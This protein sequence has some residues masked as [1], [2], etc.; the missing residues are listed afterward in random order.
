M[1]ICTKCHTPRRDDEFGASLLGR[2]G[3]STWCL[4]CFREYNRQY[5]KQRRQDPTHREQQRRYAETRDPDHVRTIRQAS[6]H[7]KYV[8]FNAL[9][10]E[11]CLD[12]CRSFD[13]CCMD[14][15]HVHGNKVKDLAKMVVSN[16]RERVLAEIAKCE[17]VCACCHRVRTSIQR[18]N[19]RH[20]ASTINIRTFYEKIDVLKSSP[21]TDC[22][23]VFPAA[24][25]FDHIL[26]EKETEIASMH[27]QPWTQVLVEL[28]KCELVC[29]CCHRLRTKSRRSAEAA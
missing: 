10:S 25:D 26:G 20:R 2:D 9:K 6:N 12:C 19:P 5:A 13:P 21:C 18:A 11:P 3:K 28:A 22:G 7:R 23:L 27:S 29:A 4:V 16:S 15:D 24:M 14:F 17:L 1:K 8:W